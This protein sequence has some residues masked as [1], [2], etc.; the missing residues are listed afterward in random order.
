MKKQLLFFLLLFTIQL[1]LQSQ[2]E[3]NIW[4][5]GGNA[6]ISFNN[7]NNAPSSLTNGKVNTLEGSSAISSK[8]GKLLF[9]TD[10]VQV[11]NKNHLPMNN[12]SGLKGNYSACQSAL[13]IKQPNKKDSIYYIFTTDDNVSGNGFNYSIVNMN[14]SNSFGNITTKN[15]LIDK[16]INEKLCGTQNPTFDVFWLATY[17]GSKGEYRVYKLDSNGFNSAKFS[18][19]T[20]DTSNDTRSQSK[21][22]L[23]TKKYANI[24]RSSR[25]INL[26]DFN[27]LTGILSNL[28]SLKVPYDPYGIE[29]SP[30]GN[31]LYV[32]CNSESNI[33]KSDGSSYLIVFD[34][35]AND[36]QSSQKVVKS[37]GNL[38]GY[39]LALLGMQL[40][41]DYKIYVSI[42][43]QKFIGVITNPDL[44]FDQCSYVNEGFPLIGGVCLSSLPSI[45]LP[46]AP[47]LIT[48]TEI[49]ICEGDTLVLD[50]NLSQPIN[51]S[52]F[53]F[54][55]NNYTS[56]LQL[57]KI[58]NVTPSNEGVYSLESTD[59]LGRKYRAFIKVIVIPKDNVKILNDNNFQICGNNPILLKL[60]KKPNNILWSNKSKLDNITVNT[61]GTYTVKYWDSNGSCTFTEIANVTIGSKPNVKI[62]I[63]Q[64]GDD[65][66]TVPYKLSADKD[67]KTYIWSN[68]ATTKETSIYN[69][70]KYTLKVTNDFGCEGIDSIIINTG[71]KPIF[72]L[73]AMPSS[74]F[75]NGENI[76]LDV[77]PKLANSTYLWSTG[78]KTDNISVNKSGIYTVVVI[79]KTSGCRDSLVTNVTK[80]D[81]INSKITGNDYI[82]NNSISKLSA[83]LINNNC[84]YL[85]S[86]G[87]TTNSITINIAGK[88]WLKTTLNNMCFIYDTLNVK[89]INIDFNIIGA[90]SICNNESSVLTL[91]RDFNKYLWSTGEIAKSININ[92]AGNYSCTITSNNGC[93]NEKTFKVLNKNI[94]YNLSSNSISFSNL[95]IN[96][97]INKS[98]II[99]NKSNENISFKFKNKNISN[100]IIDKNMMDLLPNE[101]KNLTITFYP[102]NFIDYIDTLVCET[103]SPCKTQTLV[104]MNGSGI[105]TASI[106]ISSLTAT[107]NTKDFE[108]PIVFKLNDLINEKYNL[109]LNYNILLSSLPF[110]S[111]NIVGVKTGLNNILKYNFTSLYSGSN[112]NI[113]K[114]DNLIGDVLL[115]DTTYY[116][117]DFSDLI[118][119]NKNLVV[120][121]TNGQIELKGFCSPMLRN[122]TNTE[123]LNF[124]ISTNPTS[125]ELNI[126]FNN[127][128]NCKIKLEFYDILGNNI[129]TFKD[130]KNIIDY[131]KKVNIENIN[132]GNYYVKVFLNEYYIQTNTINII[133]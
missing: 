112:N 70:G 63:T 131:R 71:N 59:G 62:N 33:G 24:V 13:I 92:Q 22:S 90:S 89:L 6:G 69:K 32:T 46:A 44:K 54:G 121:P 82:C 116:N 30:S 91:D 34:L 31:N 52:Y 76:K 56:T 20:G 35:L 7:T 86:T 3:Y 40:A 17:L 66:F 83:S 9:Y 23:N 124:Q 85:W 8:D 133:K 77:Q 126:I 42:G 25:K 47:Y 53:W 28:T 79:D 119:N 49:K 73:N 12:G 27:N 21:F 72:L 120:V 117:I 87:E 105:A 102:T 68:G 100:F 80:I 97:S 94:D 98:L 10:G 125:N 48:K 14:Q 99:S 5:F 38:N 29:F 103:I 65:C 55:P 58:P 95:K 109:N 61:A 1:K 75:C 118:T 127:D 132:S 115:G 81:A 60:S 108:I 19:L 37:V 78:E 43:E 88:Y 110:N 107:P 15:I 51:I 64:T 50:A 101:N 84:T 57:S 106:S 39:T 18:V 93:T 123:L 128:F 104:P 16:N 41:P 67:Y 36:I 2:A 4:Y 129:Y 45:L 130:D 113:F 111:K 114:L 11:W 74:T 96:S 26:M 122:I